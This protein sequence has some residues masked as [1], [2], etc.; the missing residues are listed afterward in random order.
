MSREVALQETLRLAVADWITRLDGS[1]FEERRLYARSAAVFFS[2]YSETLLW[3][4]DMTALA[5][6]KLAMGIAACAYQP[7]GIK[8]FDMHFMAEQSEPT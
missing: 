3:K 8:V 1:S 6:K 4:D 5:F 2:K 7:G